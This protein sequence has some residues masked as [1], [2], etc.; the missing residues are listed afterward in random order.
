MFLNIA[1]T[2]IRGE[3]CMRSYRSWVS[4][5][6]IYLVWLVLFLSCL[7]LSTFPLLEMDENTSFFSDARLPEKNLIFDRPSTR[8]SS[9]PSLSGPS[10]PRSPL[11][12]FYSKR[13]L[14]Q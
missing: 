10:R 5:S 13:P 4:S 7:R 8:D 14:H 9:F 6:F 12:I 11:T 1:F 2:S 3:D